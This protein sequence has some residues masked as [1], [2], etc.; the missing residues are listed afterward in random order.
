MDF[1]TLS[2]IMFFSKK[3]WRGVTNE[4]KE[5]LFFIFNRYMA[6]QYPKQAELFNIK[7]IDKA[8]CMDIWFNFLKKEFKVPFWFWKGPTKKKS[9]D[10][11]GW[12]ILQEFDSFLKQE[13]I[14]MLCKL[15]PK[16][17]KDE[18]KRLE[19]IKKEQA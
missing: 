8:T 13:D 3:D 10:I 15:F 5:S 18:I 11:K 2:N 19:T 17:V 4:D 16:E 7:E 1:K 6:K 9:P 14:L 12:E